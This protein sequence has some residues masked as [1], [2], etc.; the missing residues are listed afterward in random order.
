MLIFCL[1]SETHYDPH[2]L[3]LALG[4]SSHTWSLQHLSALFES[5]RSSTLNMYRQAL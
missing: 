3:I 1:M 2:H 5:I 4:Y